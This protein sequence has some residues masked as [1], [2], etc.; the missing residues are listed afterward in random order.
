ME[1]IN[2]VCISHGGIHEDYVESVGISVVDMFIAAVWPG[3][4]GQD[5]LYQRVS[6]SCFKLKHSVGIVM[7]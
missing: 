1:G 5:S 7:E 2:E 6:I 3:T 4:V